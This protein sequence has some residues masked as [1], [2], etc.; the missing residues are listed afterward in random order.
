MLFIDKPSKQGQGR[1][2]C[3]LLGYQ[4]PNLRDIV[5]VS[6]DRRTLWIIR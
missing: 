1:G 4:R 3:E 6:K 2:L 5:W